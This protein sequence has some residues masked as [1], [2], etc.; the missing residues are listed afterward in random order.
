ME[1]KSIEGL[2]E[3]KRTFTVEGLGDF[4]ISQPSA[5]EIRQSDWHYSKVFNEALVEGITTSGEML[6]ILKRRN[7][8]GKDYEEKVETL[9]TTIGEKIVEMELESDN[10]RR[11]VL[12]IEVA[13]LRE[14]LFQWNQRV[15]SPMSNTCEQ[16]AED[17]RL[18]YLTSCMVCKTDN[19]RLW[20]DFDIYQREPNRALAFQARIEVM[21]FLQGLSPD[22]LEKTPENMV[23]KE[24]AEAELS[25][26]RSKE[27]AEDI[28]ASA[29]AKRGRKKKV[30]AK[31][32]EK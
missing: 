6:E 3:E 28:K 30:S 16:L 8:I 17:A 13:Q 25:A 12:A 29:P 10:D 4:V 1:D 31:A 27:K 2:I 14:D 20:P 21:L 18:D 5:D 7:L 26:D 9:K 19:T 22:F 15:N 11:R 24:I 23:L 32:S